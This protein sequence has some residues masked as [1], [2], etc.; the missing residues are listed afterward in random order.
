MVKDLQY[1]INAENEFCKKHPDYGEC[2]FDTSINEMS[3]RGINDRLNFLSDRVISNCNKII[4][5]PS[6]KEL[7]FGLSDAQRVL[8]M[9]FL[10]K[11]SYIFRDD[12]YYEGINDFIQNL[13]DTLDDMVNKV[14]INSDSKLY[15]FCNDYDK[16][17]MKVGDIITV[18][19]NLTC[20]NIDWHQ[21]RWNNVYVISPLN[22]GETR[23]RNIFEICKNT[24]EMQ[25]DFLRNTK[26]QVERIDYTKGT[27]YKK[28][29]L[30]E[31]N[32][33]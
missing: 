17:D 15:R 18:P 25:I 24:G 30:K 3:E 14:P 16:S 2:F 32:H 11:Y 26:F 13:L 20:T 27:E 21:E 19:H 4:K 33:V 7:E 9:L 10:G 1:F 12:Y 31:L 8:L 6:E 28:F 23:A 29:Y 5:E 22:N